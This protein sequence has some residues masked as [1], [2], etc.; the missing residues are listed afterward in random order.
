MKHTIEQGFRFIKN[1]TLG[2][3][4]VYLKK[5]ERIGALMAIMT[6]CLLIYGLTLDFGNL[7]EK[8]RCASQRRYYHSAL[9]RLQ[10]FQNHRLTSSPHPMCFMERFPLSIYQ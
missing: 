2:L 5:P 9:I 1:D 10:F 4:E 6:L 7:L 3:D 8:K